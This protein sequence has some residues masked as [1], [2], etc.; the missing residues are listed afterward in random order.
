MVGPISTSTAIGMSLSLMHSMDGGQA[1][2]Q[3]DKRTRGR[4]RRMDQA[5]QTN[6]SNA[7]TRTSEDGTL[8][9]TSATPPSY[10]SIAVPRGFRFPSFSEMK[11]MQ[12]HR[13][14]IAVI[15]SAAEVIKERGSEG[16]V[17]AGAGRH[18]GKTRC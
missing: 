4:A 5:R 14:Y 3:E 8:V 17:R 16:A 10:Q 15:G 12:A 9:A 13:T 1:R 18:L 11:H 2:G 7:D 6:T